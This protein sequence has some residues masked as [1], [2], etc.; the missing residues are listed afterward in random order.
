MRSSPAGRPPS[1]RIGAS[2]FARCCVPADASGRAVEDDADGVGGHDLSIVIARASG[3][4]GIL[5]AMPRH[6]VCLTFDFDT[7]SGF[8][9]RG[10]TTPTPLS[11]GEFGAMAS[12]RILKFLKERSIKATWFTPGF[13]IES[14]P[15]ES[16]AVA[17]A[18]HEIGAPFLG[19]HP[20]REPDPR[21]GGGRSRPRQREHPQAHRPDRARLPLAVVGLERAHHRSAHQAWLSLRLEPDGRRLH[22]LPRAARRRGGARQAVQVRRADRA[23][24]NADLLVARRP[25]AFRVHPHAADGVRRACSRRG[26]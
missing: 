26:R 10:M 2:A 18:G 7:Q 6:I 22:S 16:A 8:I 24:R 1:S 13:T 4:S 3:Q 19:A 12:G 9:A 11:R 17:E 15:K 14:W 23:D 20:E 5:K 25:P 21:G